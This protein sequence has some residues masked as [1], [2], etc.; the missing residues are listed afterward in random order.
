M[1][2]IPHSD[3]IKAEKELKNVFVFVSQAP[4]ANQLLLCPLYIVNKIPLVSSIA[5]GACWHLLMG[6]MCDASKY[7]SLPNDQDEK[8]PYLPPL[9]RFPSL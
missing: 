9:L 1:F 7:E 5:S 4:V 6:F 3:V 8:A 2:I